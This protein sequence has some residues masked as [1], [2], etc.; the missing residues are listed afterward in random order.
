LGGAV[1]ALL[2][3]P[4]LVMYSLVDNFAV[5]GVTGVAALF[6]ACRAAASPRPGRWLVA[7]GALVGVAT[8]ARIDGLLLA[9]AP[10]VAWALRAREL[11]VARA[12]GIGLGTAGICLLVLSPWIVRDVAVFGSPLPSTGGHTLWITSYNDQFSIGHEISFGRYFSVLGPSGVIGSKAG[13]LIDLVGRTAVLCGGIFVIFFLAGLWFERRNRTLQ[14]FIAY[15]LAMLGVMTVAFTFHAPQGAFYH[16]APA[17]LPFAL[18]MSVANLP[19]T[20][21]ALSRWWRFLGR[22]AAQRFLLVVGL[23]GAVALSLVGSVVLLTQWDAS[24]RQDL[25]AASFLHSKPG[26]VV[27]SDDPASLWLVS[28]NPAI[29]I[30]FDPYPVVEQAARAYGVQYLVVNIRPGEA[31]DPLGLWAG[32]N[33]VDAQG[34][35]ATWLPTTPVFEAP[36]VRIYE[37]RK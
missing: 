20:C 6:A 18:P 25:A 34:N 27:M 32:G 9:V 15:W 33:A 12:V 37:V 13:A 17:W 26:A 14:P 21:A 5:F 1:L 31:V 10:A 16:S 29:P 23:V 2:A 3:G 36:N 24:H 28:G 30:P 4:L 7:S 35:R 8:L 19:P 22:A 11:G